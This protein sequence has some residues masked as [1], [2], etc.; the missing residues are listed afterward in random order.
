MGDLAM[1][2][3]DND[4]EY[5][6]LEQAADWLEDAAEIFYDNGQTVLHLEASI[7]E[8]RLRMIRKAERH[9]HHT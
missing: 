5:M 8:T 7:E 9:L 2:I 4:G 3:V 6:C 1:Q